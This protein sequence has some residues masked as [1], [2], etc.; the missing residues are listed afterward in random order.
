MAVE[1]T[2]SDPR[3]LNLEKQVEI[4]QTRGWK[5][6]KPQINSLNKTYDL[7]RKEDG[8]ASTFIAPEL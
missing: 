8:Y 2:G 6:A 4:I 1:R 5:F 7:G 3:P